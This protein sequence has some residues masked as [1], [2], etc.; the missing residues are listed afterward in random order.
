M[1]KTSLIFLIFVSLNLNAQWVT[2]T[3]QNTEVVTSNSDDIKAIGTSTGETYVV[4][5]KVVSAPINYELRLQVLDAFGNK[6]L[7]DDGILISD[8]L[9]MSTSTSISKITIDENNNLYVGVTGTSDN[10]GH[11]FKM[12]IN[13]NHLW[14]SNGVSLGSGFLVTI[15]PLSTGGAVITWLANGQTLIQKYDSS[16]IPVWGT[17]QQVSTGSSGT[18]GPGDLFELSGGNFV[19]VFHVV[20]SGINSTLYA[21][22][23]NS[24]GMPQWATPTQLSNKST[25]Y[26]SIY[27]GAQDGDLIYYGY[28]AS[29]S[30]RFDSYLQRID[31]DGTLPWGI[32]GKDF[33]VNQTDYEMD[34][35]IAFSPGSQYV[36]AICSYTNTSQSQFGEY[37]QKF[38]KTT[39]ARQF[40]E[41]AKMIYP[42]GSYKVH[43]ADLKL[44]NDQPLFLIKSGLD[45][46]VSPTTLNACLLDN[47]GNFVWAEETKPLATFTA[48][49]SRIQF[50]K[51]VNGNVVTVFVEQK[52]SSNSKIYAQNIFNTALLSVNDMNYYNEKVTFINP[53]QNELKLTSDTKMTSLYIYNVLGQEIYKI[54]DLNVEEIIIN[55][56]KWNSGTYFLSLKMNSRIEKKIKIIKK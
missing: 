40:S 49:K 7:G 16:G 15:L 33:D 9:P 17:N 14:N 50:T 35:R 48:N 34:T 47:N 42:I 8:T 18:K 36:W 10:S 43:A 55:S 53:I 39:G 27:S 30:N 52:V 38:D 51:P 21:Q 28:K 46:G 6:T 26:N 56:E 23:Y 31:S 2:D 19:L 37:I 4:F 54:L 13:G 20:S 11:A 3:A 22:K 5:W 32:N 29:G 24:S 25:T 41:N 12:D 45:N 1:K 44:I